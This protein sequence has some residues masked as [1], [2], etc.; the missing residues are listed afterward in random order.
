MADPDETRKPSDPEEGKDT[1]ATAA[2]P[3]PEGG[4]D[5]AAEAGSPSEDAA[6]E[7]ERPEAYE[8][9]TLPEADASQPADNAL[10]EDALSGDAETAE[11]GEAAE[12]TPDTE[13]GGDMAARPWG[14]GEDRLDESASDAEEGAEEEAAEDS[15]VAEAGALAAGAAAGATAAGSGAATDAEE[16]AAGASEKAAPPTREVVVRKGGFWSML[17]GGAVAVAAGFGAAQFI[18]PEAIGLPGR[19]SAETEAALSEQSDRIA[20]LQEQVQ[21]LSENAPD[22]SQ[23]D[24]RMEEMSGTLG[25]LQSD[26][27]RL[28]GEIETLSA[29]AARLDEIEARLTEVE[30][31]PAS[32]NVEAEVIEAYERELQALQESVAAQRAE[33]ERM[34]EEATAR[35]ADAEEA[36]RKAEAVAALARIVSAIDAGQP[37]AAALEDLQGAVDEEVPQGLSAPAA[38]GVASLAALQDSF[39]E[40]ARA[41]LAAAREAEAPPEDAGDRLVSFLREELGARSTT[42]KE[43]DDADAVLSRAEAALRA[44][45]LAA[46][47]EELAAL[48][49]PTQAEMAAWQARARARVDAA[50]AA[51]ALTRRLNEE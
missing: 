34:V 39:P 20:A 30:K 31:R 3:E 26:V 28:S 42:A 23:F 12:E 50:T 49:E 32:E 51:D 25:A 35:E 15:R 10:T 5:G 9:E 1:E 17:F 6:A 14:G 24:A 43:G 13:T 22:L 7:D 44:G 36:A 40:A 29:A 41:A 48:P 4:D 8:P 47:L 38:D 33:V 16:T 19:G 37:Y 2:E 11:P 18:D 27:A 46:A 45:E 21:A